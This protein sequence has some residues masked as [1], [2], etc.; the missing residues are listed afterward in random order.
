MNRMVLSLRV[1]TLF[2]NSADHWMFLKLSNHS[3]LWTGKN[4]MGIGTMRLYDTMWVTRD[5]FVVE[6]Q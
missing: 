6:V 2:T 1:G 3:A 4:G 5:D